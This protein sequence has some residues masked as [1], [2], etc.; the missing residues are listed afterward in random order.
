MTEAEAARMSPMT[1]ILPST[2]RYAFIRLDISCDFSES[3]GGIS[4]RIL[5]F[6][7]VVPGRCWCGFCL[8]DADDGEILEA[9]LDFSPVVS[10]LQ[11]SSSPATPE[12]RP[13]DHVF[14]DCLVTMGYVREVQHGLFGRVF[15]VLAY[16]RHTS[17]RTSPDALSIN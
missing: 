10:L 14:P 1:G 7:L 16:N 17:R 12:H 4:S 9:P 5:R 2:D 13:L 8:L 15:R 6:N 11:V 3:L